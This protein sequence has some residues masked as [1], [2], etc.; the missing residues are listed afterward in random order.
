MSHNKMQS[1]PFLD[2]IRLKSLDLGYNQI[3]SIDSLKGNYPAL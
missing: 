3:K 1:M 2:A